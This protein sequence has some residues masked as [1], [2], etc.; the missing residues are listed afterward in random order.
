M[1]HYYNDVDTEVCEWI[2]GLIAGGLVPDGFVDCRSILDVEPEDLR[3]FTQCHFFAGI[4]GWPRALRLAGISP[5][6]PLWTGS[7]PCQPFS[8]AGAKKGK[9]DAR[10]L[11]PKFASLVGA[12]RPAMLFGEQVAS[13]DVFG[14]AAKPSKRS[15]Q[16][17]WAWIDDLSDRL[18]A[19]RYAVGSLDIPAAFVGAPHIRQRTFFGAIRL[20][21]ADGPKRWSEI[22][23]TAIDDREKI[24]RN[25]GSDRATERCGTV[26]RMEHPESNGRDE[27]RTEPSG[28]GVASGRG[29]KRLAD[30][31]NTG[32]QR[33]AFLSERSDQCVVGSGGVAGE[34]TD[35]ADHGWQDADWLWC[36]DEK[37]R[38]VE[39]GSFPL[40]DGLPAGM[41][42]LSPEQQ[43]LACLAGLDAQSLKRAKRYRVAT[44]RG[45][46]NAIVPDAA[47][48]F[49]RIFAEAVST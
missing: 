31:D 46:G 14:K 5:D 9:D 22:D 38:P 42:K 47:A 20:A 11:A 1:G 33:R 27:R 35:T 6:T 36:R 17:Q 45:Y 16:P 37:W 19:S 13:S 48:A 28:R 40:V 15:G 49:I 10:H 21:D 32:P 43:R 4:L 44:L 3:E 30:A 18:E 29:D 23:R 34:R 24:E 41:G 39:P 12:G 8:A 2:S 7:P 25:E 26:Q